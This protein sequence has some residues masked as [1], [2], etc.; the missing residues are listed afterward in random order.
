MCSVPKRSMATFAALALLG[1]AAGASASST[2][3]YSPIGTYDP[4]TYT[5]T[6]AKTGEVDAYF[7]TASA[8][9]T[10]TV[11]MLVNGVSTGII[12]LNNQTSTIGQKLDLGNVTKGDKIVFHL[13]IIQTG[14][15]S[16]P[17]I[18]DAPTGDIYS[19]SSMNT[20]Y[21]TGSA[22]G[23]GHNHLYVTPFVFAG[24]GPFPHTYFLGWEDQSY[25]VT[26]YDYNDLQ[27][28]VTNV[29]ATAVPEPEAWTLLLVGFAGLGA[30]LRA[31]SRR[32]AAV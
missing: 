23:G 32:A 3:P 19:L 11:G 1:G 8:W 24:F 10:D 26:D 7:A 28:V 30:L 22:P 27:L 16:L 20:A 6:A 2:I 5:F 18:P 31:R 25:P 14:D 12:G 17:P 4:T 13:H 21:D 9:Y 29:N 15:P